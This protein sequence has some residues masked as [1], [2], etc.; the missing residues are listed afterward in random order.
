MTGLVLMREGG[1][2]WAGVWYLSALLLA[3]TIV[4]L[5]V[6]WR[7]FAPAP[8]SDRSLKF[9]RTAYVWLFVSLAMLLSLPLYQFIVLPGLAAQSEAAQREKG[10][11]ERPTLSPRNQKNKTV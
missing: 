9:L 10:K 8:E 4:A 7:I 1:R 6:D 5:V 2:Y 11:P 3:A